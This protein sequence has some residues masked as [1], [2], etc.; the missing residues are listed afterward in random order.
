MFAER[1]MVA[2]AHP[3]TVETGLEILRQGGNAIDAAV[4]A[5]LTAAVVMPEMCGLGGDLF[6]VVHRPGET[7]PGEIV[8]IQ[9]SGIASKSTSLEQMRAAKEGPFPGRGPTSIA[10]PGMID[11]FFVLL[12]RFGSKRFAEVVEQAIAYADGFPIHPLGAQCILDHEELLAQFPASHAVFFPGGRAPRAGE[13]FRQPGLA[14]TL[15]TLAAE[16]R[17][18]FYTG[19]V[20]QAMAT[21]LAELGGGIT[22]DDLATQHA[23]VTDP[24]RT[25]YRDYTVY[26][27]CLPS[28]GMILLEALNIV[29]QATLAGLPLDG[30][31]A[32]HLLVEAKKRAFADRIGYAID[33]AVGETPVAEILSKAWAKRRFA[34]IDPQRASV[35]VPAGEYVHGDTTYLCVVDGDGMMVSLIES[36]A[37]NFGSGVVAGETGVVL[38]NRASAF[39]LEDGHPNIYA[40]G[41][42]TIHTLN[43]FLIADPS[44]QPVVV[45]GTPGG[46]GQPQWNLQTI[47]GLID[48]GYDV[49][50][51]AEQP[52]WVNWPGQAARFGDVD[53]DLQVETRV[54]DET[55]SGLEARGHRVTRLD[56]WGAGGAVQVIARDPKTG[57]LAGGSDPRVEGLAAGY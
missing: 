42:K 41:K 21:A 47:V 25:T 23:D 51:V 3:L 56:A 7:G 19:S 36:V 54:D 6:A 53:F 1:G 46:D 35:N 4:G 20:G 8:S 52:R 43:C 14:Q 24:I 18:A 22:V 38:N 17:D 31:E 55:L 28:Q 50:Q 15:R 40:P 57:V 27:T 13:I 48:A 44:G 33:P 32:I 2:A 29:E 37:A 16:G 9:G 26:Q 11:A 12:E 5:G 39:S 49:Q 34:E 10:V 45:G 30:P